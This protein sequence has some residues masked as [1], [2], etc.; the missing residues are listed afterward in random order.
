MHLFVEVLVLAWE[1]Q[2]NFH[3]AQ[4]I[5]CDVFCI[6]PLLALCRSAQGTVLRFW[7]AV[8]F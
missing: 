5:S 4:N 1:I 3:F 6:T 7:F 2:L 8:Q